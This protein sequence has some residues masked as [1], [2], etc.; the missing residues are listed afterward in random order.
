MIL[1]IS[2]F[3]AF[4]FIAFVLGLQSLIF[5]PLTIIY[6]IW[7]RLFFMK[8][9]EDY[10]PRISVLIPAYN[11]ENTIRACVDSLLESR[12]PNF[13]VIVINDGSTDGTEEK[14][15]DLV[16]DNKIIYLY[17]EHQG[18]AA[19][20]NKG[21]ETCSGEIV[22]YTDADSFFLPNTIEKIARWFINPDVEAVCGN[23]TPIMPKS[24]IQKLLVITT[25]IGT[26]FVRRALSVISCLPIITGNLGA[27][28]KKTIQSLGGFLSIPGEDLE[29]TFRLHKNRKKII[30]DPEPIVLAECP[31]NL[32]NLWKQRVR[33]MRSYLQVCKLHK[34]IFFN[35]RYLP[36]SFYL[37]INFVSMV[38]I[39]LL[40]IITLIILPFIL[41]AG[42]YSF[43]SPLSYIAYTGIGF[44]FII[45]I[46]SCLIDKSIKDLRFLIPYGFLILPLSYFYDFVVIYSLA[47]Q[48]V[49]YQQAWELIEKRQLE[50]PIILLGKRTIS[51]ISSIVA[52]IILILS[53]VIILY[54]YSGRAYKAIEIPSKKIFVIA[55]HFDA[56]NDWTKAIN[57]VLNSP[58]RNYFNAVAVSAGRTEWTYFK[59]KNHFSNWSNHQKNSNKDLLQTAISEFAKKKFP[60][61]G[62]VDLYAPK[63]IN[64]H[65]EAAAIGFDGKKSNEQ[66]CFIELVQGN[67]GKLVLE[68]IKYLAENYPLIAIDLTELNYYSFCYDDRC[69]K[70]YQTYTGRR[71]WKRSI[72]T[73]KISRDDPFV[74]QWRSALM[75]EYIAKVSNIVHKRNKQLY[76][77]VP[78]SWDNFKK[79]AKEFGLDYE[80]MTKAADKL[81]IWD[82]FY[83]HEKKPEISQD[84]AIYL[85]QRYGNQKIIISIGLWGKK[86]I[87]TPEELT[88]ATYNIFKGGINNIWFTPNSLLTPLHWKELEVIFKFSYKE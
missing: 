54:F 17:T 18:K 78:V 85:N 5:L 19:A 16:R 10:F 41:K 24:A 34:D 79:E 61:I 9:R 36:F 37:P 77:D 70:S 29:I 26:G 46:Y 58:G 3:Y 27:I 71:S 74:W 12:Y 15:K 73:N 14:I 59:W 55:T 56:W 50:K 4:G 80:L 86:R 82:Y 30:F 53:T 84:L 76:V 57:S 38:I 42:V 64:Q 23:D 52:I 31:S 49:S 66:V 13:E 40:Q 65:P 51:F 1:L 32:K 2:L 44:F 68:L 75:A 6:E 83:L 62:I 25:H 28:R 87:I 81:I 7:K 45:S 47:K 67:Y 60:T 33:W 11:E 8:W 22:I 35:L 39:P 88:I 48:K 69:L 43:S 72:F 63:Y 21:I 20:L